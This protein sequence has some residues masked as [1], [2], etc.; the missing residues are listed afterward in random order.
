MQKFLDLQSVF[1]VCSAVHFVLFLAMVMVQRAR[2]T[3]PG[4]KEWTTGSAFLFFGA[5]LYPLQN[6]LP[7]L[8][9]VVIPNLLLVGYWLLMLRGLKVFADHRPG[10]VFDIAILA[11]TTGALFFSIYG[12][13]SPSLRVCAM[14]LIAISLCAAC[15]VFIAEKDIFAGR[16]IRPWLLTNFALSMGWLGFRIVIIASFALYYHV[17]SWAPR[18]FLDLTQIYLAV[19]HISVVCGFILLNFER[20]ESEL[21]V[22][23]QELQSKEAQLRIV[24]DSIPNG[25]I[26][27]MAVNSDRSR[28][29]LYISAGAKETTGFTAEEL[30]QDSQ[31][32]YDQLVAHEFTQLLAAEREAVKTLSPLDI[33]LR[34]QRKSGE[35]RWI[36][37]RCAP[38]RLDDGHIV[39]DGVMLD[40]TDSKVAALTVERSRRRLQLALEASKM[41]IWQQRIET[42]EI[43]W[44]NRTREIFGFAPNEASPSA[45][46]FTNL[47]HPDDRS[48]VERAWNEFLAHRALYRVNFRA[49]HRDGRIRFINSR[50]VFQSEETE[51]PTQIVGVDTD[52]TEM[53]NTVEESGRLREKLRQA[54]KLEVL[55]TMTASVVHDFNN[56]LTGINGFVELGMDSLPPDHES[57]DLFQRARTTIDNARNIVRQMLMYSRRMPKDEKSNVHLASIV[58]ESEA[59]LKTLIPS[60]LTLVLNLSESTPPICADA[61]QIQ[62]VLVNL[63]VNAAHAIG[64]AS[65]VIEIQLNRVEIRKG[66]AVAI[67]PGSYANLSVTDTG[68]GMTEEVRA[69]IFEP[70]FTTKKNREGTGLGLSVVNEIISDHS[71]VIHVTTELGRGTKFDLYFP[72]HPLMGAKNDSGSVDVSK[73]S[74]G[75]RVLVVDDNE[76]VGLLAQKALALDSFASDIFNSSSEAWARLSDE[77]VRYDLVLADYNMPGLSGVELSR[78]VRQKF[79]M[80]PILIMTGLGD[81]L[82]M[83]ELRVLGNVTVL[84]KPFDLV[85]LRQKITTALQLSLV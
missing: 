18:I 76:E 2:R 68:S 1:V 75:Q 12:Y 84:P 9:T 21:G 11:I 63:C 5:A 19:I 6:A 34:M 77:S 4:F 62:Q 38:R 3:Y 7:P 66:D 47:I 72:L 57:M 28:H 30:I 58:R 52:I 40:I 80:L 64:N 14:A 83:T 82:D 26:Y 22:T 50:A 54:Q 15:S 67:E 39:W 53:T 74:T 85:D 69:R 61:G 24:G 44:D 56:L 36:H 60:H 29:F 81:N 46:E 23:Q 78:R 27:Q 37:S 31:I 45:K 42:G 73:Q 8:A 13:K 70:F 65:G 16:A 35:I 43:E 48:S 41:G 71:G 55:G 59:L 51:Q 79:P 20:A 17:G 25:F 33:V 10:L 32:F 49:R